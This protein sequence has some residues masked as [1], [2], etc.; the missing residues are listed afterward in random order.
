M[1]RLKHDHV[2]QIFGANLNLNYSLLVCALKSQGD[3][4]NFLRYNPSA[5]RRKLVKN[6]FVVV[7]GTALFITFDTQCYEVSLGLA[8]L[9][10]NAVIHGDI[11]PVNILSS[12]MFFY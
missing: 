9:H 6:N 8:Y 10:E 12:V 11:K 3:V 5:N 2:L 4:C 7:C 1:K